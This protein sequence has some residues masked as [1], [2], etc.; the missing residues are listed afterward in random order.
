MPHLQAINSRKEFT[1]FIAMKE[2]ISVQQAITRARLLL[3]PLVVVPVLLLPISMRILL[4]MVG[5]GV[6]SVITFIAILIAIMA[7]VL[8]YWKQSMIYWQA[9]AYSNVTNLHELDKAATIAGITNGYISIGDIEKRHPEL[10]NSIRQYFNRPYTP[11]DDVSVPYET[12]IY[13]RRIYQQPVFH[14]AL[15]VCAFG[16][17]AMTAGVYEI[18]LLCLLPALGLTI[19][20]YIATSDRQPQIVLNENG[21]DSKG[22]FTPWSE[23]T[24]EFVAR[25]AVG[26]SRKFYLNYGTPDGYHKI[27]I[28]DWEVRPVALNHLLFVYRDRYTLKNAYRKKN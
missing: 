18:G 5:D 3:A 23:I 27:K 16:I 15:A 1:I 22:I 7:M 6:G 17:L 12:A 25:V 20:R 11:A 28:D 26:K 9:W 4:P 10:L 24:E 19:W 21:L 13:Y 8:I 2:T 14:I